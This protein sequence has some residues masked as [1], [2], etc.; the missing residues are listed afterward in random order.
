MARKANGEEHGPAAQISGQQTRS[1]ARPR[2]EVAKAALHPRPRQKSN[3]R[4]KLLENEA[5]VALYHL[6]DRRPARYLASRPTR[7]RGPRLELAQDR[8][9]PGFVLGLGSTC[10]SKTAASRGR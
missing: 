9:L 4:G 5:A 6:A 1:Q 3:S 10:W 7:G 8:G 2:G